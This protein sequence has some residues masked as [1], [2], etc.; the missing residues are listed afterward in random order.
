MLSRLLFASKLLPLLQA[1]SSDLAR[2]V[3]VLAGA[4]EGPIDTT[5][6]Q[7]LKQNPMKGR[8]H[9]CTMMTLALEHL[10]KEAPE[11]GFINDYP[12]FVNT[13]AYSKATGVLGVVVRAVM[14]LFGW[15]LVVP[16]EESAAR[17][18]FL[19]TSEAYKARSAKKNG[20]PLVAGLV[21][22]PGTEGVGSGVYSVQSNSESVG[23]AGMAI[24]EQYRKDGTADKVWEYISSEFDRVLG[25]A[26]SNIT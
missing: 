12:G 23:D 20:V 3:S 22:R 19:S 9:S 15:W 2:V 17:H 14:F 21:T 1:G 8:G 16:L 10:A 11:V 18:V 24:L 5:D 13:P 4:H 7:V 26:N 6:W 25:A